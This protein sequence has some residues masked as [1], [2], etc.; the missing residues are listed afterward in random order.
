MHKLSNKNKIILLCTIA[1]L[2]ALAYLFVDVNFKFFDYAM[3]IRLPK[4]LAMTVSAFCIG[5]A[6]IVFQTIINNRIVTPSLLGMNSL[7]VLTNT[8]I[9]MFIG[10]STFLFL[11]KN[12]NFIINLIVM[13]ILSTLIYSFLLKKTKYNVLYILLAGTVLSTLFSSISNTLIR[14][15][16][17]N[18]YATLQNQIIT[19]FDNANYEIIAISVILIG[20]IIFALRKELRLLNVMGL[21]KDQAVNL[22]VDYDKTMSRLLL[23]I[24]LFISIATALVGPIS[25]LGLILANVSRQMFKTYKHDYLIYGASLVGIIILL[26]GQTIIEHVFSFGTVISV[27]INIFGGLYFLYLILSENKGA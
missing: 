5:S 4:L 20:L 7:Y 10:S 11:G 22:G 17:P 2:A 25:F 19:G 21:G 24:T 27:F 12:G 15:M 8:V 23:G 9:Y 3:S 26:V 14:I 6:S 13:G 16:D 18:E 1:I